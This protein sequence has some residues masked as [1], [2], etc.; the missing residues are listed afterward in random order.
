MDSALSSFLNGLGTA[1]QNFAPQGYGSA[2]YP[3]PATGATGYNGVAPSSTGIGS[4]FT[5][6]TGGLSTTGILILAGVAAI[7]IVIAL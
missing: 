2:N 5:S 4:L 7:V 6:P 1:G 3:A